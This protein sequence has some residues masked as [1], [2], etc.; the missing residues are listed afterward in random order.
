MQWSQR[1][2]LTALVSL[3]C[4]GACD[5]SGDDPAAEDTNDSAATT[6]PGGT[7]PPAAPTIHEPLGA[8]IPAL[9]SITLT[10]TPN[11]DWSFYDLP[12]SSRAW[13][14]GVAGEEGTIG[15][16]AVAEPGSDPLVPEYFHTIFTEGVPFVTFESEE[17]EDTTPGPTAPTTPVE[18]TSDDG[19]AVDTTEPE[20]TPSIV[21]LSPKWQ[22]VG[23]NAVAVA[24]V[25]AGALRAWIWEHDGRIWIMRG[26]AD[27]GAPYVEQLLTAMNAGSEP[28]DDRVLSATLRDRLVD[29][30]GYRYADVPRRDVLGLLPETL[31]A[32]CAESAYVGYV[33]TED[34][35]DPE[36]KEPEDPG[37]FITGVSG[38]CEEAG[39]LDELTATLDEQEDLRKE[40][41]GGRDVWRSERE[42]IAFDGPVIIHF[43]FEEPSSMDEMEPFLEAFFAGQ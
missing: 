21:N 23:P 42:I 28:Y 31:A 8:V 14:V 43:L 24:T 26:A 16:L 1:V 38:L 6:A 35:P 4:L 36:T 9:P 34:D 40:Q 19:T 3:A 33:V 7:Q 18:T 39:L 32:S 17:T 37:L 29:V 12:A 10:P 20:P 15:Q 25:D 27:T 22:A 41:I 2:A 5:S 13:V 11:V 30:P